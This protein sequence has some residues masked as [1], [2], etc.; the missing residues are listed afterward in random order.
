MNSKYMNTRFLSPGFTILFFFILFR[1]QYLVAAPSFYGAAKHYISVSLSGGYTKDFA[2]GA[3]VSGQRIPVAALGNG[4]THLGLGYGYQN[5]SF[6]LSLGIE[7]QLLLGT[8]TLNN[9]G[10]IHI[11]IYDTQG[12]LVQMNYHINQHREEELKAFVNV[13][14][15]F[16]Y[17][18]LNGFYVGGGI[19]VGYGVY[20]SDNVRINYETSAT[21]SNYV[22]DFSDM[23]NHYYGHYE[24]TNKEKIPVTFHGAFVAE[25]G[26]D[27]LSNTQLS[28][29]A[30]CRIL[31]LGLFAEYGVATYKKTESKEQLISPNPNNAC[32]V[33]PYSIYGVSPGMSYTMPFYAGIR[34][35]ILLRISTPHSQ[36]NCF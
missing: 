8:H 23:P 22:D 26:Y 12:K 18:H 28:S 33:T 2:A 7:G 6:W 20:A 25:I 14:L 21:Y 24:T 5:N 31:R 27:I 30:A 1:T 15:M 35:T 32:L 13:P 9:M 34:M 4:G 3:I 17:C 11:P 19:K 29:N 16:G 10:D 36:C